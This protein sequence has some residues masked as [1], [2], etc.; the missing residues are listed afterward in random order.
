MDFLISQN[1]M[2]KRDTRENYPLKSD[3]KRDVLP[4][5][6]QMPCMDTLLAHNC[7]ESL[8]TRVTRGTLIKTGQKWTPY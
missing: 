4:K 5:T 3:N 8:V 6:G 1:F 2:Q 7:S